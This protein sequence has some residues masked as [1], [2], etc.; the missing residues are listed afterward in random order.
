MVARS[1]EWEMKVERLYAAA[2]T[3][4]DQ[5]DLYISSFAIVHEKIKHAQ[6]FFIL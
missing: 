6:L 4:R 2:Q 5:L 3:P 1:C